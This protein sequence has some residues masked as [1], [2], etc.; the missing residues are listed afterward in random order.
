M[1]GAGGGIGRAIVQRFLSE[2]AHVVAVDRREDSL[3]HLK[4]SLDR[5]EYLMTSV[6]DVTREDECKNLRSYVRSRWA[7]L[8]ILVNNAGYFPR[9]SFEEIGLEE[10]R[11]VLAVNL[12]SV[13]LMTKALLALLK[14]SKRGRV[15]NIGSSSVF[16]GPKLQGHYVAA[17]AGVV[18]LS[19]VLANELG[20]FGIT[21]NVVTPGLTATDEALKIFGSQSFDVRAK[22]SPLGRLQSCADV[23][24][25]VLYLAS[26]DASAVT[27]QILNID[28]GVLTR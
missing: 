21:V 19:R 25:G 28:G 23:A 24:G 16:K 8:D 4:E 27:G 6:V 22:A 18:G 13:F 3:C 17:K 15:I 11:H 9:A 2:G 26:D 20:A 1:T 10:W 7:H 14:E 5:T 12:D